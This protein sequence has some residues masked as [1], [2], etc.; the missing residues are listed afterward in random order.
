VP[1]DE[2][3]EF[4]APSLD[5]ETDQWV[6]HVGPAG[7][8]LD[9]PFASV[10]AQ[11]AAEGDRK[12]DI[13]PDIE[14]VFTFKKQHANER[15]AHAAVLPIWEAW[16]LEET[17]TNAGR[18][19][20]FEL[21][22]AGGLIVDCAPSQGQ[23]KTYVVTGQGS[24]Y[25]RPPDAPVVLEQLPGPPTALV[26]DQHVRTILRRWQRY[27]VGADTLPAAAYACL[28]YVEATFGGPGQAA[29]QLGISR[30]V[31]RKVSELSSRIGDDA[32]ARKFDRAPRRAHTP[33]E[34][35]FLEAAITAIIRRVAEVAATGDAS[36]LGVI[37]VSDLRSG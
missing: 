9:G 26:V 4:R 18:P 34:T 16:E 25:V 28:T 19:P 6:L 10:V 32:T 23:E 35:A 29:A 3:T 30:G 27:L 8:T 14:A 15:S 22:L 5:R 24:L 37:D 2:A 31:L 12:L 7:E 13:R 17:L 33:D 20:R 1:T 21:E 36:R 11:P